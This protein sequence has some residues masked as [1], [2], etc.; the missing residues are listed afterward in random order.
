[1]VLRTLRFCNLLL[2]ALTFGLTFCHLMEIPGKLRL[3]GAEWLTVQHNLYIAFG[4]PLG[5]WTP[6]TLPGDWTLYRDRW[7]TG[8][9]VHCILFALGFGALVIAL[10]AET[11]RGGRAG[12]A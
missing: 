5:A 4:P 12:T 6:E 1:M 3:G 7:E 10:L 9:A 8:H 11:P 2:V